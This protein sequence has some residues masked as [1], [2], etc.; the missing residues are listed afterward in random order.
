MNRPVSQPKDPRAPSI[1][2]SPVT[3]RPRLTA[4][5]PS[6]NR[7]GRAY[8]GHTLTEAKAAAAAARDA[9]LNWRRVPF[10]ERSGLLHA[11][12]SALRKNRDRLCE[13]MTSEM[14]KTITDGRAE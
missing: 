9:W 5:D 3:E 1:A 10:A 4:I 14:G 2:A 7:P 8:E 13:L 6:T 11:A 12:A